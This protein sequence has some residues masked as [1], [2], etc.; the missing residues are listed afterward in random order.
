MRRSLTLIR[1]RVADLA[2]Y[3]FFVVVWALAIFFTRYSTRAGKIPVFII[4]LASQ[5]GQ[6]SEPP[7]ATYMPLYLS[8]Q[9]CLVFTCIGLVLSARWVDRANPVWLSAM[10]ATL[11]G[12]SIYLRA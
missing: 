11:Q 2:L 8:D 12:L 1:A 3:L 5:T 10:L 7:H 4:M 9:T 6:T